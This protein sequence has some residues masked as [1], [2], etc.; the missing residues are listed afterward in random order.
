M[1]SR[2][3]LE[4]PALSSWDLQSAIPLLSVSAA[5]SAAESSLP[6]ASPVYSS[7]SEYSAAASE[8]ALFVKHAL[9]SALSS[10]ATCI[11]SSSESCHLSL[12]RSPGVRKSTSST[13]NLSVAPPGIFGGDPASPYA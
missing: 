12:S 6:S 3:D 2:R 5:T 10:V 11:F 9:P 13:S 1:V 7:A 8:N 4:A